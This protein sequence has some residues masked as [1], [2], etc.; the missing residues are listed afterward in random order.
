MIN[1]TKE[2]ENVK[3]VAMAGHVRPDGDAIGACLAL[4]L[5]LEENYPQILSKIYL[6]E[7]PV[8]FSRIYGVD[9]ICLDC[10]E[11]VTYD[12]FICLDCADEERLGDAAKYCR[13]ARRTI[14][15]DHHVSNSGFGDACDI[16]PDASSTC[17]LVF[18]LLDEEKLP[19]HAAE[20][21][22]MGIAHDTGVFRYS[23]TSPETMEIAARLIRKGVDFPKLLNE[24]FF[25]KTY[26]QKQIM[27]RALLESI[28]LMDKKVIF[29]AIRAKD[30]KIYNVEPAD[31]DGVVENLMQTSGTEAAIFMYETGASEYKVSLRSKEVIDCSE[32]ASR[33]GGGGHVRAAGCTMQGDIHD[34]VNNITERMEQQFLQA[35]GSNS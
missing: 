3:T 12:L 10:G 4:S 23:C 35:E 17:E 7:I 8:G 24:T 11:D 13:S 31:M 34:I 1:L 30:M 25:D 22:Y 6:Q 15:I 32:I 2:L 16:V 33:F 14:C 18:R 19:L 29:S 5:Y 9:R 28:L 21:L 20:A 27:G 26:Y